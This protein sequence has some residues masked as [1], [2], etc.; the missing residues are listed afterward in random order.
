MSL[1]GLAILISLGS[2]QMSRKAEKDRLIAQV[3][4]RRLGAP[5]ALSNIVSTTDLEKI[6]YQRVT[7]SGS[8]I[9]GAAKFYYA[10]DERLGPGYDVY[11]PL[12]YAPHK[13]V[14]VNRG[15]IP[16][17]LRDE[18]SKWQSSGSV[19][20]S[21][22]VRLPAHPGSF[23]PPNDPA[24]NIWY[25]RDV[26]GMQRSAFGISEGPQIEAAPFFVVAEAEDGQEPA[27]QW[28]RPGVS[29]L[30]IF[31]KHL[32]YALTWYGLA[33][34]LFGVYATFAWTRLAKSPERGEEA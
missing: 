34:T 11:E 16:Q 19:T 13:V 28:P 22:H 30:E 10:P 20:I 21:G 26:E 24:K 5:V 15:Y 7:V 27:D 9:E 2:W 12:E 29:K 17:A 33:L 14:W 31:N 32:E 25:W 3:D 4:A 18:P 8:F 6:D 1:V 23:T